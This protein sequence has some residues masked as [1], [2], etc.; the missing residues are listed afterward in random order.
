MVEASAGDK[1]IAK[2]VKLLVA[3]ADYLKFV[4]MMCRRAEI[5]AATDEC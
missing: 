3:R 2:M 4:A 5:A 1:S